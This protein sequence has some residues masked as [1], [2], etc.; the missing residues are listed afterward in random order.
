MGHVA[1]CVVTEDIYATVVL[2]LDLPACSEACKD[3]VI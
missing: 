1:V 2:T 3:F